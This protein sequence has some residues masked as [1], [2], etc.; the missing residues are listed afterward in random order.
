MYGGL[1]SIGVSNG[2]VKSQFI[3]TFKGDSEGTTGDALVRISIE[4]LPVLRFDVE[5]YGIPYNKKIGHEV[6]VNFI[7]PEI[8]NKGIFYTDASGLAMQKRQLNFRPTWDLQLTQN[9]NITANY[10]PVQSAIAIVEDDWQLTVMN[11]RSQGGSVIV[12]GRIE[13]MQNRRINN[14]DW[15][16]MGE[17]LNETDAN[18]D[19][20]SVPATYFVQLFDRSQRK[21]LQRV[22]QQRQDQ[23]A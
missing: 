19:G 2:L 17:P 13:L 22:I 15:R 18:G 9:Q 3:L 4:D 10:Y 7:A 16:G 12:D 11:S 8:N 20:I 1:E 5:L 21:S 23:P 6:T 14:D